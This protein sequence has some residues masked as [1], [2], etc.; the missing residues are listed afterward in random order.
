M[1]LVY[2]VNDKAQDNGDHEV[3]NAGCSYL[4]KIQ[5]KSY[6]GL[7]DNCSDAVAEAKKIYYQSNGCYW[8]SNECHTS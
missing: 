7:F 1:K 2:Y 5:S 3:H 4:D 6:L 8:C